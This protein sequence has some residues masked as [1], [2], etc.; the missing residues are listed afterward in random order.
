MNIVIFGATGMVAQ[1]VLRECV[2]DAGVERVLCVGRKASGVAHPKVTDLIGGATENALM[3]L[4]FKATYMFRPGGI[5]PLHK[6]RS[7]T[8]LHHA[9][10]WLASP[11]LG[12]LARMA[13]RWFT[14]GEQVGRAMLVVARRG[15]PSPLFES[16]DINALR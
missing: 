6:V 16:I 10:Y 2:I 14:T 8:P 5:Q 1:G 15:A 4:P 13:P 12:L 11:L 7:K 9:A 3:R